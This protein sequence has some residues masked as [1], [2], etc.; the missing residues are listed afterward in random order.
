MVAYIRVSHGSC[1]DTP[2]TAHRGMRQESFGMSDVMF[3]SPNVVSCFF[4]RHDKIFF[5]RQI[6]AFDFS[7]FPHTIG[8]P[9]VVFPFAT[10]TF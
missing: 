3:G 8:I 5:G 2:A 10:H 1:V 4:V 7:S 9:T 6:V